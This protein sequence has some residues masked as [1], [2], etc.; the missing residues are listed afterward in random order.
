MALRRVYR[1]ALRTRVRQLNI[2]DPPGS[3]RSPARRASVLAQAGSCFSGQ[4]AAPGRGVE[5]RARPCEASH[6]IRQGVFILMTQRDIA[7]LVLRRSRTR[8]EVRRAK[9]P[10]GRSA[11][12]P[13]TRSPP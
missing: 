13:V 5:A 6:S 7:P 9:G 12:S 1:Q 10:G 3:G 8:P 4:L 11:R 2:R